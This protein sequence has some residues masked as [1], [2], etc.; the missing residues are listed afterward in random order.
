[1]LLTSEVLG[2]N[3]ALGSVVGG[4]EDTQFERFTRMMKLV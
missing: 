4:A 2:L 1:M 3:G